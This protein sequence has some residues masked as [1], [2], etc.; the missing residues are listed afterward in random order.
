MSKREKSIGSIVFGTS[1][2][3][4]DEYILGIKSIISLGISKEQAVKDLAAIDDMMAMQR[5]ES[6]FN[7]QR[8]TSKG[9]IRKNSSF[10][11]IISNRI[12]LLIQN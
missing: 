12:D 1:V 2:I 9:R 11:E 8:F 5:I 7:S 10:T 6:V 4:T 3:K